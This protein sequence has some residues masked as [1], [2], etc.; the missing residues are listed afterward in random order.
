MTWKGSERERHFDQCGRGRVIDVDRPSSVPTKKERE[1][2][3]QDRYSLPNPL[4]A[5]MYDG[6]EVCLTNTGKTGS[7]LVVR[8]GE[9]GEQAL[10]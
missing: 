10:L 2:E 6:A 3:T 9:L 4:V 1:K 5:V 8:H 7:E